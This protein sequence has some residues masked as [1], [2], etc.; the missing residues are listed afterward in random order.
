[1][2]LP[3]ALPLAAAIAAVSA[4]ATTAIFSGPGFINIQ[5]PTVQ[6]APIETGNSFVALAVV[7]HFHE[8]KPSGSSRVTVG[9]EVYP[10]NRPKLLKHASNGGFR[11]V[12]TEVTYEYILHLIL[13]SE[14]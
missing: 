5:R 7:T 6:V 4:T 10:V 9:N 14:I 11:C 8:S 3:A 1:L 12:E 2:Q 13:L